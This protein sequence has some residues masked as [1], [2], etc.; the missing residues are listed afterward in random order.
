MAKSTNG[1]RKAR[2]S[3]VPA[4]VLGA[5][6]DL[7]AAAQH[8]SAPVTGKAAKEIRKLGKQLDAAR[9]TEAKRLGQ[10]AKAE[11]SKGRKQVAKRQRQAGE[12]AAEVASLV[13]RI[14]D[15]PLAEVP[16]ADAIVRVSGQVPH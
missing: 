3:S 9:A 12:A 1:S 11:A 4:D 2:G 15:E 7:V 14:G 6:G 5:V 8:A 13:A 10:L 16:R